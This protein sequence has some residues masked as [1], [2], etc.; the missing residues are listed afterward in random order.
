MKEG[1]DGISQGKDTVVLHTR[2]NNK[3]SMLG[4]DFPLCLFPGLLCRGSNEHERENAGP[5][6]I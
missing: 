1:Y 4:G 2:N 3:G 5:A 6:Y